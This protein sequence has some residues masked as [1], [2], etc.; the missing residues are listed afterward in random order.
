MKKFFKSIDIAA[1]LSALYFGAVWMAYIY[2]NLTNS[3]K[4]TLMFT[5]FILI[6]S[7]FVLSIVIRRLRAFDI[8]GTTALSRS[9]KQFL[10]TATA[11][12][13]FLLRL[14][15][16]LA[17]YP[18][19][20]PL[21]SIA[22]YEQAVSGSY[23]DWHPVWH[24][25]L[26][27]TI[28]LKIFGK[29]A[30]IIILQNIYLALILGYMA[31]TITEIWNVKAA[32]M[33][34][35][36][37]VLNP[38]IGYVMLYPWKDVA[39]ALG[40]LLCSIIAVKLVLK[41]EETYKLWKLIA[42]GILLSWTTIFRHNAILFT[43]PLIVVLAFHVDKKTWLKIFAAFAVSLF[44]IKVPLYNALDVEKPGNR[45]VESMG[46]P[47]TVIGNVVK[48]MPDQLGEELSEFAYSIAPKEM[49]VNRYICGDFNSIKW[50]GGVDTSAVEKQ[51][52]FGMLKLMLLSF[53]VSPQAA[54][55]AFITLTDVVYGFET[56]LEGDV[57]AKIFKNDYGIAYSDDRNVAFETL[58]STYSSFINGTV[59][60]YLRTYG[61][62]LFAMLVLVLSR[63][64]YNSWKSWK[65]AIFIL[66]PIFCYDFGT[67]LLLTTADSRFFFITFL[68]TP[69]I[70]AFA[71][72]KSGEK[73][74][75]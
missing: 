45:V 9:K 70:I 16:I 22:Q 28:P 65:K 7:Y 64:K 25:I 75:G 42:L 35:A 51:G 17:Y 41:R 67:M 69:L 47:L 72:T 68:V 43:A 33:S 21:D 26:F 60:K 37:I 54:F 63:L 10:F 52:Y 74:N 11:V 15:W 18:G 61:V 20:F 66:A 53:R 48:V 19:S 57:G 27:F 71:L 59:F 32:I 50:R 39:F 3:V 24:T 38:Y 30:A 4:L 56:G 46:L 1:L 2:L 8:L 73:N 23:S 62:A 34:I 55:R 44:V 49:W 29:P 40:G 14:I 58:V 6:S 13:A 36:Y 31:V 12:V 5:L